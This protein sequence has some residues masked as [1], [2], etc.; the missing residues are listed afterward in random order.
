MPTQA[1][2]ID[3]EQLAMD[4]AENAIRRTLY[5]YCRGIDRR[6][7]DLVRDC[8][9][10]NAMDDHG[11]YLGGVDGFIEHVKTNLARFERTMHFLGNILVEVDLRA[12][13]ARSEAYAIANHRLRANAKKPL[14]DFI[15]GL[16]YVDDFQRREGMWRIANR[17]CVFEWSRIDPVA[18]GPFAFGTGHTLGRHGN[19]DVVFLERL[20]SVIDAKRTS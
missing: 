9:H 6:D 16:R 19:E 17:V 12:N 5:R 18:D 11:D 4:V 3:E 20:S 15:V 1:F 7:Y 2:Q 14:R 8:Y 10:P 13:H